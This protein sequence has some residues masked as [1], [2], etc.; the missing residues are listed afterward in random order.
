MAVPEKSR[1]GL[2]GAICL[3]LLLL[4]GVAVAG[5]VYHHATK[6]VTLAEMG[7][8]D[9]SYASWSIGDSAS[10]QPWSIT[11]NVH[12]INNSD[13]ER[14]I[15]FCARKDKGWTDNCYTYNVPPHRTMR[16]PVTIRHA[17][18]GLDDQ[19][20]TGTNARVVKVD[21]FKVRAK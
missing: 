5:N 13:E 17:S 9:K 8:E 3:V 16:G 20:I 15:K 6:E 11:I 19:N 12:T 2:V 4:A 1:S 14:K 7:I 18:H 10:I 21:G